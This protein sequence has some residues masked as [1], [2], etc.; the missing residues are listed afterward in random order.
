MNMKCLLFLALLVSNSWAAQPTSFTYQGKALNAAGTAPLTTTVS[1]TLS[2]TD[3]SGSCILYQESQSNINLSTTNGLFALQ[4]GSAVGAGKRTSGTDPGLSMTQI[5]ANAGTQIVAASGSCTSGYTPTLGDIRKLHVIVT[6]TSGS[7][8]TISPDLSI[9]SVPNSL[10][11]DTLQGSTLAQVQSPTGTLIAFT[12]STCPSG[13][14]AADGSS[15][16]TTTYANLFGVM[17]YGY[18]GSGA[19]FN[20]PNTGGIFLRGIGSQTISGTSYTTSTIGTSQSD[21]MQGHI[22]NFLSNGQRVRLVDVDSVTGE[23]NS[24]SGPYQTIDISTGGSAVNDG[25]NG[26]PRTGAETRPANVSVQ[27]CVKY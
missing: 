18:G 21:Q 11:A 3:P 23:G 26:T 16:S 1:F 9:N 7:P 2:I 13:Y 15:Y 14:L 19:S 20:V 22:H 12:S 17:G 4:V 6:P 24:P 10:V 8:I 25:T 5:F 27:Y